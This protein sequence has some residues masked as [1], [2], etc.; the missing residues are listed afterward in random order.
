MKYTIVYKEGD[1]KYH[2]DGYVQPFIGNH[3]E[4]IGKKHRIRELDDALS[5]SHMLAIL[6]EHNI[7]IDILEEDGSKLE[8]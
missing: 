4:F 3:L 6:S 5:E 8:W 7:L 2:M 1:E